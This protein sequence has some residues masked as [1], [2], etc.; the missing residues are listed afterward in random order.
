[1]NTKTI[2]QQP[3]NALYERMAKLPAR[4]SPAAAGDFQGDIQFDFSGA[5]AG[6]YY[7]HIENGGCS[8]VDGLSSAPKVTMHLSS[9]DWQAMG[10]GELSGPEAFM[11]GK[12]KADGDF[13]LLMRWQSFFAT[14]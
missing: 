10:R 8:F 13:G 7:L 2:L 3:T 1:M 6:Q 4:F 5:E 9:E 14:A 11:S 12:L